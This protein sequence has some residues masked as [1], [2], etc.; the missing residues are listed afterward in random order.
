MTIHCSIEKPFFR[1]AGCG[2]EFEHHWVPKTFNVGI[3]SATLREPTVP[4]MQATH[5]R[6]TDIHLM[7]ALTSPSPVPVSIHTWTPTS[8]ASVA[9]CASHS[10]KRASST[11]ALSPRPYSRSKPALLQGAHVS[12]QH[13]HRQPWSPWRYTR[14]HVPAPLAQ[15]GSLI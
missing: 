8:L 5:V 10:G 13:W 14:S 3:A 7:T 1:L 15:I 6:S 11:G 12:G 4:K 9:H 2:G